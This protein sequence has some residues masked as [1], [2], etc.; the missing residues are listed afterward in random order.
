[1]VCQ[2]CGIRPA[3]LHFTK[4]VNGEK[5]EF[6][7]CETCAREKG[8]MI[9]GTANGFSI[10]SLLSGLLDLDPSGKGQLSGAKAPQVPRCEECGMT[11]TQFSK[12]GRFGCSSCYSYFSDR[13]DPLFKR[14]HGSTTHVG[15]V[16]KRSG[17]RIQ[18][19]RKIAELKKELHEHIVQEEFETAAQ[20]RDQIRE[21][22]KG[23]TP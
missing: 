6:H 2:E 1:M 16:P 3:T 12:L 14:V 7:F 11:Y 23:L 8:E 4:I 5:T 15:K 18:T 13:L 21:L 17:G 22:E 20:I 19:K 9:P 10:H